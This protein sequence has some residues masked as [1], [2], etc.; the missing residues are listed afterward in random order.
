MIKIWE[1]K[2]LI[3]NFLLP[4]SFLYFILKKIYKIFKTEKVCNVPVLCVGNITLGGAGKTPTVIEIRKLLRSYIKNIFVLTRGYKGKKKGPFIVKKNSIFQDVGEESLIHAKYGPTCVSKNKYYGAK[5]CQ[6]LGCKL[7][8]MDDGLQSIDIK[9]NFKILVIDGIFGFG[10]KNIFP[11]GPLR[12]S[13]EESINN[14]DIILFLGKRSFLKKYNEIPKE[15]IFFGHKIIHT[16]K[17]KNNKLFVFSGLG[18]NQN[19]YNSLIERGFEI[20]RFKE[21]AD[22]YVFK[23]EDIKKIIDE[24]KHKKLSIVCTCKDFIKVPDE[25]KKII[26]PVGLDLRIEESQKLKNIILKSLN[27]R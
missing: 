26:F 5:L 22:H 9:K 3:S 1:T 12:E 21:F 17:L 25:F 14:S 20:V 19:F 23:K 8:I 6:D 11:A 2:N 15:K 18:N 13:I 27:F 10:N 24:A 4:L 7:I 16:R